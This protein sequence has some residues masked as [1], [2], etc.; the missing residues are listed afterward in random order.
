MNRRC[1]LLLFLL[2]ASVQAWCNDEVAWDTYS[3]TWVTVDGL[4]RKV[5][6]SLDGLS[7]PK[8]RLVGMFYYICNDQYSFLEGHPIHD[9][10]EILKKNPANPDWGDNVSDP[11]FWGKP[12]LGY[13]VTTDNYLFY[14]HM[15]MMMDSGVDFLFFDCTNAVTY[16]DAVL[17]VMKEIDRRQA[18]GMK[19]PKLAYMLHTEPASTLYNLY[20]KFYCDSTYNK[21]WFMW[22]GKPLV[23]T[24]ADEVKTLPQKIQDRFTYRFS[25]AWLKGQQADQWAWLENYPQEAGW[26]AG[27]FGTKVVEQI[28]VSV[29]QHANSKIGKSYHNGF[30][31]AYNAYAVCKATPY[32]LYY[33]EQWKRALAVD[34]PLVMITQM[35]ECTAGRFVVT[36]ESQFGAV[37]PGAIPKIGECYFIDEYNA[38][39]S[40]DLEP[41]TDSLM[42]DNYLMQTF[43]N[44]RKYKGVR[45]VPI[46]S[47][48][49]TIKVYGKMSQWDDVTPEFRDDRGDIM[50]R[51]TDGW[52]RMDPHVNTSGRNDIVAAKVTKDASYVYFYVRTRAA[53]TDSKTSNNWMMLYINSDCDYTT[54]WEGYDYMVTNDSVKGFSILL[55]NN[56]GYKWTKVG[57]LTR[58]VVDS[59]MCISIPRADIGM[60]TAKDFDFKWADN[61]PSNPDILDFYLDGDVAPNG[62]FNYRY[63][64]S[65]AGSGVDNVATAGNTLNLARS[66]DVVSV[67]YNATEGCNA[68]VQVYN[69]LGALIVNKPLKLNSG[70]N[71][72]NL[73]ISQHGLIVRIVTENGATSVSKLF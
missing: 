48:D 18:L 55:K 13:Y 28:S 59:E 47:A 17:N 45:E 2:L 30:E 38:E 72:F 60:E 49:R 33:A 35:N 44:I 34:P 12:L 67:G 58:F 40:R 6:T 39:Y 37:R 27:P 10:T 69:M 73:D 19:T 23:L 22:K 24:S 66:G 21:Y 15:Q 4:G 9:I 70:E 20:L 25:W 14:K 3:D 65:V 54:G 1:L 62:R 53:M 52:N 32:G 5:S 31:P 68:T 46:P 16:N 64:G 41:H 8:D 11:Y 71:T 26:T 36:D 56:G 7:A 61:T 42:R 57:S 29:A 51:N 43:D 63:R 50:H